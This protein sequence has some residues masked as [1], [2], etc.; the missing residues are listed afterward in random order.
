MKILR[1]LP[2]LLLGQVALGQDMRPANFDHP[3]VD[4]RMDIALTAQL[5]QV[6]R[7]VHDGHGQPI[8]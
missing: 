4:R 8:P 7:S 6:A 2:L 5:V 3:E 1:L